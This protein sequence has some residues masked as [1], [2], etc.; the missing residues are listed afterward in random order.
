MNAKAIAGSA[1]VAVAALAASGAYAQQAPA[2]EFAFEKC[3]GVAAAGKNDCETATNSCAGTS[4]LDH[5][6]DAWIYVPSGTCAKIA[7]G[8][9]QPKS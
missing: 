5:Q 6:A 1:V 7:G 8:T 3:L 9:V 2:P 4:S